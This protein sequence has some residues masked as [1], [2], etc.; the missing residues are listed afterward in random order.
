VN[1]TLLIVSQSPDTP[2]ALSAML[3]PKAWK[4]HQAQTCG[5]AIARLDVES[6][7]VVVC[8]SG[9]PDGS[10][11]D[12]LAYTAYAPNGPALIVT[13]RA[14]DEALW[15]EVLNLGGYDVLAQ[16]FDQLEVTRVICSAGH[17]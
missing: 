9:L 4:V 12:M 14:A 8:D 3:E 16:P 1:S 5:E 11:K 13:S 2:A 10:W 6:I 15:A 17:A 7:A